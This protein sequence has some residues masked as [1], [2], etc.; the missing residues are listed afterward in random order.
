M[1]TVEKADILRMVETMSRR[2]RQALSILGI[3]KA[4]TTGGARGK[5]IR[6]TVKDRGT[7]LLLQKKIR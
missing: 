5:L 1:S 4:T 7:G 2:K 6:E 3:P